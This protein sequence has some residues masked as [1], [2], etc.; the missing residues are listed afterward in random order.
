MDSVLQ[1]EESAEKSEQKNVM[2]VHFSKINHTRHVGAKKNNCEGGA[3]RN[4][5]GRGQVT[6]LW[7]PDTHFFSRGDQVAKADTGADRVAAALGPV[8]YTSSQ[9]GRD[10]TFW[11]PQYMFF[12]F[13]VVSPLLLACLCPSRHPGGDELQGN[14]AAAHLEPRVLCVPSSPSTLRHTRGL[15]KQKPLLVGV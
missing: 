6:G 7:A 3:Q 5:R 4:G 8:S 2:M 13:S 15:I 10:P 9:R 11:C 14:E 12:C 1:K